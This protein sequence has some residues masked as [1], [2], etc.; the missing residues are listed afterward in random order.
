MSMIHIY[1][2]QRT[3]NRLIDEHGDNALKEANAQYLEVMKRN[4]LQASIVWMQIIDI[5]L[6]H[7]AAQKASA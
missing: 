4:D 5:I 2:I 7:K 1:D 6:D 3:A